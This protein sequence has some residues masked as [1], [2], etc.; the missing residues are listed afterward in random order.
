MHAVNEEFRPGYYRDK[1]GNWQKE[2]RGTPDR[3][4]AND[5]FPHKDRRITGRRKADHEYLERSTKEM[6]ADALEEFAAEHPRP[7]E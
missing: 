1:E 4:R 7:H 6:I 3:R 2:R 5:G